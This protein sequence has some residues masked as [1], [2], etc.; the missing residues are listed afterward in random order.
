MTGTGSLRNS[1]IVINIM[2]LDLQIIILKI[3]KF[4]GLTVEEKTRK[5]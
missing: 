5:N 3:K 2:L 1:V 4:E